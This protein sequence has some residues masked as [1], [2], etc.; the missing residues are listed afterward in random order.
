M[1]R[2][3]K[4]PQ[5]GGELRPSWASVPG[6]NRHISTMVKNQGAVYGVSRDAEEHFLV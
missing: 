5:P 3:T 1:A 2:R 4:R 6:A